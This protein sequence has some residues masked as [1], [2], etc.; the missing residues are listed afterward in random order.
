MIP[1][2]KTEP[3]AIDRAEVR[4]FQERYGIK[5]D[6]KVGRQT[7]DQVKL[8][9]QA[10]SEEAADNAFLERQLDECKSKPEKQC[11]PWGFLAGAVALVVAWATG[12]LDFVSALF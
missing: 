12:I 8:I 10:Y 4:A 11:S 1:A 6:G 7:W 2:T 5:V 9:E 3:G